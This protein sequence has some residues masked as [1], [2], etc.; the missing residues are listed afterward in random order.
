VERRR[1]CGRCR[2]DFRLDID[3]DLVFQIHVLQHFARVSLEINLHGG[4]TLT[5]LEFLQ[6]T[7]LDFLQWTELD[8]LQRTELDYAGPRARV[9]GVGHMVR[10]M[11][12]V[13]E[14]QCSRKVGGI[15]DVRPIDA[16]EGRDAWVL[17]RGDSDNGHGRSSSKQCQ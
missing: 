7:E 9:L 1:R 4:A 6:W 3:L 11:L 5:G 8:F 15:E 10:T 12:L 13:L 14:A 2:L 17:I 16:M